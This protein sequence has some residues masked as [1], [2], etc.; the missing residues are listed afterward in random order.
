[1]QVF[2]QYRR[3][4][5]THGVK[6]DNDWQRLNRIC[7]NICF[8]ASSKWWWYIIETLLLSTFD[9]PNIYWIERCAF[10]ICPRN[11]TELPINWIFD[12]EY[13]DN[14]RGIT[15]R[16]WN[17]HQLNTWIVLLAGTALEPELVFLF[18]TSLSAHLATVCLVLPTSNGH[19][20]WLRRVYCPLTE[21]KLCKCGK[22]WL[23]LK[24]IWVGGKVCERPDRQAHK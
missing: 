22:R 19:T 21:Y 14:C 7:Q 8:R 1:M 3:N 2:E 9:D 5:L 10:N 12:W 18:R 4:K 17:V 11:R 16:P 20:Q 24:N 15:G 23:G 13:D 6:C